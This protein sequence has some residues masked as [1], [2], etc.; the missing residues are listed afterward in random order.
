VDPIRL[1]ADLVAIPSI[2]PM[3]R[4]VSGPQYLETR[5]ADYLVAFFDRLG[6][7]CERKTVLPGRDNVIARYHAPDADGHRVLLFDAHQDTVPVDGMTIDPFDPI[8][9]GGRM[10]GRGSC[11]IKG[12]MAAM[13]AAFARL[14]RE[15]PVGS[16][17]VIMACTVDEEFTHKG[18]SQLA[19]DRV[20]ADLAI[21]AEPTMLNI[22]TC[23]KGAIRWKIRAHGVACHSSTPDRGD[24]AIY[25]MARVVDVLRKY[26]AE[27]Q[28]R[29]GHPILGPPSLSVGRIEGGQSVNI[30]PDWCEVEI[31]RRVVP[32]EVAA[33]CPNELRD[34]LRR[35]L[36]E[37]DQREL[38]FLPPWVNLPALGDDGSADWVGELAPIIARTSGQVPSVGGVPFGT[39]AGPIAESGVPCVVLGPGD[40]AQ[41]HTKDEWV[42]IDQ[43]ER[44]AETYFH[45]ARALGKAPPA[46]L[47]IA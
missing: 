32:G 45:L 19:E 28:T 20:R 11:D 9:A 37:A 24:N 21:V 6:V 30:V 33:D 44:A 40:I 18:S 27:L 5:V 41:A 25:R 14:V 36:D 2:N 22:V 3:G 34:Y 26:A 1:L 46:P 39:D 13:L 4:A 12:G 43:V 15:R 7:P 10:Q 16:A 8:V 35:H 42:E 31:D 38:E 47:L 29:V 17:S 23:H